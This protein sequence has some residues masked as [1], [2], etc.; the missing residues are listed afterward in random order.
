[1][2]GM[3]GSEALTESGQATECAG[4]RCCVQSLVWREPR[5]ESNRV[6]EAVYG[7]D[8]RANGSVLHAPDQ[9]MKRVRTEVNGCYEAGV[10]GVL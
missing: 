6:F 9:Q 10:L 8:L 5:G 1:M 3:Q 7:E 4:L 2:V